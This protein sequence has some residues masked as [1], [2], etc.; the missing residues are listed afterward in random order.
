MIFLLKP[1][2]KLP[3]VIKFGF[4]LGAKGPPSSPS[5]PINSG[6]TFKKVEDNVYKALFY[7]DGKIQAGTVYLI[8]KDQ[9]FMMAL[10]CPI[11]QVSCIRKYRCDSGK[12]ICLK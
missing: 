2:L 5:T 3:E 9:Q 8:D 11:S 7:A 6:I 10:T 1:L 4:L 12:W